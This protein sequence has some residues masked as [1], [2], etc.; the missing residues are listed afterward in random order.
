M[1]Q[2]KYHNEQKLPNSAAVQQK[3]VWAVAVALL[4]SRARTCFSCTLADS[5]EEAASI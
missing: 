1:L 2:D 5:L 3:L 4:L